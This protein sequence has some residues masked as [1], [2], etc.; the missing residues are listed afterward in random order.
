MG[1]VL[2]RKFTKED[3]EEY[4]GEYIYSAWIYCEKEEVG[5]EIEF[6]LDL[7]F[8]PLMIDWEGNEKSIKKNS[9]IKLSSTPIFLLNSS[10]IKYELYLILLVLLSL[11]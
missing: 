4:Y 7:S 11:L 6:E 9:K 8:N 1:I 10:F 2:K 3:G 5:G